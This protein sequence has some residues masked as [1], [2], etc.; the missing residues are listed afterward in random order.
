MTETGKVEVRSGLIKVGWEPTWV[1]V[2]QLAATCNYAIPSF[3][4]LGKVIH[5][6]HGR[7]IYIDRGSNTLA[8]AHLDT[9]CNSSEYRV[10]DNI[11]FHPALDDRLGVYMLLYMLLGTKKVNYDILLTEGEEIGKSTAKFFVTDRPYDWMFEIDRGGEDVVMY[12]YDK[13]EHRSLLKEYGFTPGIGSS[14]DIR[15]LSHL[16]I[17]GFNFGCGYY[18]NHSPNAYCT[19]DFVEDQAARIIEFVNGNKGIKMPYD[20]KSPTQ[21]ITNILTSTRYYGESFRQNKP[22]HQPTNGNLPTI[23]EKVGDSCPLCKSIMCD[24]LI[25]CPM[26]NFHY[27]RNSFLHTFGLCQNCLAQYMGV[28]DL[29]ISNIESMINYDESVNKVMALLGGSKW[30]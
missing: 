5:T 30:I 7:Y 23:V 6:Q 26:C 8:V 29:T 19:L 27:H 16:G 4:K 24:G 21:C 17:T 1:D 13:P 2:K 10:Q 9:V 22:Q 18:N 3:D 28:D 14:S 15:Y 20:P 11:F 12:E 25:K